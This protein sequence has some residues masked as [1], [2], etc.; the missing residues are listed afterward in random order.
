MRT[1][2]GKHSEAFWPSLVMKKWLN[3]KPKVYD[4]SEDE[5]DTETESED[6]ACSLKDANMQVDE[7]HAHRTHRIQSIFSCQ[8][9]DT[10]SKGYQLRHRR[11]KSETLRAQYINTKDVRVTIGTWNVAGRLPC[12]DL[13]IDD[14]LCTEEPADIYI[15]GF[16][17]VVPLNAGNVLGAEDSSPIPKWEAIIRKTLNK[18]LEPESK[19]KCYSAP[20]SPVMRT[21]SVADVLADEV[22]PLE[23][24]SDEYV[25]TTNNYDMEQEAL[26]KVIGFGMNLPLKRIY[27]I[28][29]NNLLDWPER[30]LDA[31]PQVIS[32]NSKLRRVFS[33]SGRIGFNLTDNSLPASPK[34]FSLEC[35]TLKRSHHSSGSAN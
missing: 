33:S 23:M 4:F 2:R 5:V 24:M 19:H 3:I 16:Q 31:T 11:G 21:S 9:S 10:P 35:S 30:S 13:E 29:C 32:S 7:E 8:T 28:D 18:S 26:D 25:M 1:R 22:D 27:G 6:D 15:L 20:P 17:E 14:W 34:S 12:E